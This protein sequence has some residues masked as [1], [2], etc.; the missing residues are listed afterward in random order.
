MYSVAPLSV[1]CTANEPLH[2]KFE[3]EPF[4]MSVVVVDPVHHHSMVFPEELTT[5]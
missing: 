3:V 5:L 1:S 2:E 4:D